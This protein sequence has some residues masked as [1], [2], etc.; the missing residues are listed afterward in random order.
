MQAGGKGAAVVKGAIKALNSKTAKN[1]R[2]QT[3][4]ARR[5]L[6][7][8]CSSSLVQCFFFFV[9]LFLP[10]TSPFPFHHSRFVISFQ[11]PVGKPKMK[12]PKL[13][14]KLPKLAGSKRVKPG[15]KPVVA[16]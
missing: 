10:P 11:A 3:A 9:P 1:Q 7:V 13:S 8:V 4:N 6:A 5:G 12:L 14:G 2:L 15:A 16:K